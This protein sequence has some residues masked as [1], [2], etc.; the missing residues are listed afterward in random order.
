MS[1]HDTPP[2]TAPTAR[3]LGEAQAIKWLTAYYKVVH[4]RPQRELR[5]N[6]L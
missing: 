4:R 5:K 2:T 3:E 1:A 6:L